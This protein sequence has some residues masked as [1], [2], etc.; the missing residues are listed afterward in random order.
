[1][2]THFDF[3]PVRSAN[4]LAR[5]MHAP[6]GAVT[7]H[8]DE[9]AHGAMG[10]LVHAE[11]LAAE[12][13]IVPWFTLPDGARG[14]IAIGAAREHIDRAPEGVRTLYLATHRIVR[15]THAS[16]IEASGSAVDLSA[17]DD[18][19]EPITLTVVVLL[20]GV[21]AI[22]G[23]AWY[24]TRRASIEVD[25]KNVRT[26]AL[27]AEVTALAHAQLAATGAID[28]KLYEVYKALAED[29]ARVPWVPVVVAGVVVL[30]GVGGVLAWRHL[31]ARAWGAA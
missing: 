14:V 17:F 21:A 2:D 8:G 4:I 12:A 16:A 29:E 5:M 31:K 18:L 24:F 15:A 13:G 30:G 22:V 10:A 23:T 11:L 3:D 25:G 9:W 7:M 6:S 20:L 19:G 27:L 1:M 28:P 26:T